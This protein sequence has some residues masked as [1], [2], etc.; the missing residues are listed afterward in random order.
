MPQEDDDGTLLRLPSATRS[1]MAYHDLRVL[2]DEDAKS[3]SRARSLRTTL[4]GILGD[5]VLTP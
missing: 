2:N 5:G 1:L 4:P 3:R